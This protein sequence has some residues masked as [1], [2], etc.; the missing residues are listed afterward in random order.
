MAAIPRGALVPRALVY[1]GIIEPVWPILRGGIVPTA[2]F[3]FGIAEP[4]RPIQLGGL[5]PTALGDRIP[6]PGP[7]K[8][9]RRGVFCV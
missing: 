7:H 4:A 3:Y 2:L 6:K 9:R 8:P 1:F 5:V